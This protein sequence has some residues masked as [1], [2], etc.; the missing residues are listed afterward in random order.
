MQDICMVIL[1]SFAAK[2]IELANVDP[3]AWTVNSVNDQ[4]F[5]AKKV[6]LVLTDMTD[7]VIGI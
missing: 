6:L 5:A 4:R 3:L 7:F 1:Y 2:R